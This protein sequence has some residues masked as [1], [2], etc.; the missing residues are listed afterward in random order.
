MYSVVTG[1]ADCCSSVDAVNGMIIVAVVVVVV[2]WCYRVGLWVLI[3]III[4]II[5]V[6]VIGVDHCCIGGSWLC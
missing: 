4:I 1:H 2:V 5:P 3:I 6:G